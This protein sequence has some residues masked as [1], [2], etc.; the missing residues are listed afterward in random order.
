MTPDLR[1]QYYVQKLQLR[2]VE[3]QTLV[4]ILALAIQDI[5][6]DLCGLVKFILWRLRHVFHLNASKIMSRLQHDT[7]IS[8]V[9]RIVMHKMKDDTMKEMRWI[10]SLFVVELCAGFEGEE[11]SQ[12]IIEAVSAFMETYIQ[13]EWN[14]FL[15]DL[16]T[17]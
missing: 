3:P 6:I 11:T 13:Y 2:H 12:R 14:K 16:E 8:E 10:E 17:E 7:D 5:F 4:N 15:A 9:Q 1:C